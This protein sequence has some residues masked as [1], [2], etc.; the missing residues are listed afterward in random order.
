MRETEEKAPLSPQ[1]FPAAAVAVVDNKSL[2]SNSGAQQTRSR[3]VFEFLGRRMGG[4]SS[5]SWVQ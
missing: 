2:S 3:R 4:R 5:K 1:T